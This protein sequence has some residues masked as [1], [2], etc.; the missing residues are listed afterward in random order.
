MPSRSAAATDAPYGPADPWRAM[1][2]AVDRRTA[3]GVVLGSDERIAARR[4]LDLFLGPPDAPA[5]PPRRIEVGAA[6]DLCVL[7]RP[8]ADA[9]EDLAAVRVTATLV[10]GRLVGP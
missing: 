8:L 7:D 9:L 5:G 6:A 2:A 1:A 10:A 4:A 3:A